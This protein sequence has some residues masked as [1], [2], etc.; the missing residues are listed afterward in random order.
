MRSV[1]SQMRGA[2]GASSSTAATSSSGSRTP[3]DT[4]LAAIHPCMSS[5]GP[6]LVEGG[7]IDLDHLDGLAELPWEEKDEF[8]RTDLGLSLFQTRMLKRG[9]EDRAERA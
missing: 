1:R 6:I 7:I 5:L 9:L 8:F 4:F 3:L 2:C